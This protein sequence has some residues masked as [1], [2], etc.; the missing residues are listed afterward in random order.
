MHCI[1]WLPPQIPFQHM[2]LQRAPV[3]GLSPR[4]HGLHL[5]RNRNFRLKLLRVNFFSPK[6]IAPRIS[7]H[8]LPFTDPRNHTVWVL[9]NQLTVADSRWFCGRVY[10]WDCVR[11]RLYARLCQMR[12]RTI[13]SRV[14]REYVTCCCSGTH[15]HT[16]RLTCNWSTKA[17][18]WTAPPDAWWAKWASALPSATENRLETWACR[19][20]Q[21]H[22]CFFWGF[23]WPTELYI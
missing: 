20:T 6:Q 12:K 8:N 5:C 18:L 1:C 3:R 21:T 11:R 7:P 15:T 22:K 9:R 2:W 23:F 17:L 14:Q 16:Q 4:G 13:V 10:D 19:T